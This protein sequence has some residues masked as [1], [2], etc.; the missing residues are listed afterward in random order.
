MTATQVEWA[1]TSATASSPTRKQL[2]RLAIDKIDEETG[3]GWNLAASTLDWIDSFVQKSRR[4]EYSTQYP[5]QRQLLSDQYTV[6]DVV[7]P[8]GH[9][10][11]PDTA[12]A[13]I[14]RALLDP[15]RD[16]YGLVHDMRDEHGSPS[17]CTVQVAL[18]V[19]R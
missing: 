13:A 11:K 9:M 15:A 3:C 7:M 18:G 1:V 2:R 16:E 4:N 14:E 19:L 6:F 17:Y 10:S 5:T 8:H 12:H